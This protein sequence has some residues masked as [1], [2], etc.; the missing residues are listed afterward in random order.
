[1]LP[2]QARHLTSRAGVSH[3]YGSRWPTVWGVPSRC[4]GVR[5]C[6][7]AGGALWCCDARARFFWREQTLDAAD[8]APWDLHQDSPCHL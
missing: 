3:P 5:A 8:L 2:T 4:P 6:L 7:A 1:M